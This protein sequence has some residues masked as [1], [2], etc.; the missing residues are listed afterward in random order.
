MTKLAS[1]A[2]NDPV[3]IASGPGK[4][5]H[6]TVVSIVSDSRGWLY[7]VRV[8]ERDTYGLRANELM[9]VGD[10]PLLRG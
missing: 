2:L 8:A 7:N 4:G 6:G 9:G 1:Y 10:K 5:L 3:L